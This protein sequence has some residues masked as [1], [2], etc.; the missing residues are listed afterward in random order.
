MATYIWVDIGSGNGLMPDSTKPV[1]ESMLISHQESPITFIWGQFRK[2]A[3]T[4]ISL[5]IIY[6]KFV[7]EVI[8]D[9]QRKQE[10]C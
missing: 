4:K 7:I 5:K 8:V 2:S 9:F 1:P 6:P 10:R 3:T